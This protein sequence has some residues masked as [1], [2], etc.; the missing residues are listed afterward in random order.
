MVNRFSDLLKESFFDKKVVNNIAD[1][2]KDTSTY[3]G[4]V[5]FAVEDILM[6][7]KGISEKSFS[8]LAQLKISIEETFEE[9]KV[10]IEPLVEKCLSKGYRVDYTAEIL[11]HDFFRKNKN[12]A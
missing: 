3:K 6:N 7:E 5:A 8:Q 12:E 10:L 9:N 4:K 1:I 11:Y 2:F